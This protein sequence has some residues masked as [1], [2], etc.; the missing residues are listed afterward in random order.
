MTTLLDKTIKAYIWIALAIYII[1]FVFWNNLFSYYNL[2]NITVFASYAFLLYICSIRPDDYFTK[3]RLTLTTFFYLLFFVSQYLSMS[4]FYTGN[5]MMFSEMDAKAYLKHSTHLANIPFS[6]YITYLKSI[7]W[8]YDDWGAPITLSFL[9]TIV[10][11]KLFINFCFIIMGTIGAGSLFDIGKSI[12]QVKYAYIGSLSYSLAS[13]TIFFYSSF[14]KEAILV[15]IVIESVWFL[16][17]YFSGNSFHNLIVGL[18]ISILLFFFR[19]PIAVF[20]WL[21]VVSYFIMQRGNNTNN[22]IALLV[23]FIIFSIA[24]SLIV[25]NVNRYTSGGDITRTENYTKG[26]QFTLLVS[27]FGSLIGPFP[28]MLSL[29]GGK[30]SYKALFGAGLLFKYMLFFPYWKGFMYCIRSRNVIVYPMFVFTILEM[31]GL[32]LVADGLELRKAIPHIPL[33]MLAAFWYMSEYDK[34]MDEEIYRSPYYVRTRRLFNL[35]LF[36]ILFT[37]IVWNTI[38][39][40]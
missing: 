8:G 11:S 6:Q 29:G 2:L 16:Y 13:Y 24:Y 33:F 3:K 28:E 37:T 15:F 5:T 38:R 27:A 22:A 39:L 20:L 36:F 23:I 1:L 12:M 7:G 26:N 14:L 17:K 30:L 18:S 4:D 25:E 40:S 34:D 21:A 31:S 35:C 32:A 10:P 9:L 19:P